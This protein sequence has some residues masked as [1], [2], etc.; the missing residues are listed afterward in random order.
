MATTMA[1]INVTKK[2]IQKSMLAYTDRAREISHQRLL[3]SVRSPT[4]V[5]D[6]A[7]Q[8]SFKVANLN[9]VSRSEEIP[10]ESPDPDVR[11]EPLYRSAST[12]TL[13]TDLPDSRTHPEI[14]RKPF[15]PAIDQK[16]SQS[17]SMSELFN[18]MT[19]VSNSIRRQRNR[20]G[21]RIEIVD[22]LPY[23]DFDVDSQ[24]STPR[25]VKPMSLQNSPMLN[26]GKKRNFYSK[27]NTKRPPTPP[28]ISHKQLRKRRAKKKKRKGASG[29]DD[30]K[31]FPIKKQFL[32]SELMEQELKSYIPERQPGSNLKPMYK[33][34]PEGDI[35]IPEWP[36]E[37]G[38]E[39]LVT[40]NM[41]SPAEKQ[42]S[43]AYAD[44]IKALMERNARKKIEREAAAAKKK[45]KKK[46]KFVLPKGYVSNRDSDSSSEGSDE[47]YDLDEEIS[48]EISSKTKDSGSNESPPSNEESLLTGIRDGE[49]GSDGSRSNG[50]ENG[51]PSPRSSDTPNK[52]GRT[53]TPSSIVVELKSVEPVELPISANSRLSSKN[54][55]DM[56]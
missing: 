53:F 12:C 17:F 24:Y 8:Y 56:T 47:E 52:D 19:S 25:V 51:N 26:F 31:K 21:S 36:I 23:P 4:L 33:R 30:A 55:L 10:S 35:Y 50:A 5:N 32:W 45:A 48:Q 3:S 41:E 28:R 42:L 40:R 16:S 13:R 14:W 9:R 7:F 15:L 44:E 22:I 1:E 27:K 49:S 54:E 18:S 34:T 38:L 20:G 6:D 39:K 46:V 29:K 37:I 2:D 43:G 11:I